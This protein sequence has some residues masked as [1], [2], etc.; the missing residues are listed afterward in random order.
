MGWGL[1][2]R[3]DGR[4]R[5][6][7]MGKRKHG[8]RPTNPAPTYQTKAQRAPSEEAVTVQLAALYNTIH[9]D[10]VTHISMAVGHA[11]T[12]W[13]GGT[14]DREFDTSQAKEVVLELAEWILERYSRDPRL[15]E[16]FEVKVRK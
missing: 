9:N 15:D 13:I 16:Q 6:M 8:P 14:G 5:L 12:C 7:S 2:G 3:V 4:D 10:L 1:E 11:S